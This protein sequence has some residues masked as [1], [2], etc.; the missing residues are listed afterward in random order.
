MI[1]VLILICVLILLVIVCYVYYGGLNTVICRVENQKEE[2]IVY[3][4]IIGDYKKT[5]KYT[6]KIYYELLDKEKIETTRGIAIFY[7]NPRQTDKS[8]LRSDVGCILNNPDHATLAKLSANYLVK[9]L[10]GNSFITTEFPIKGSL[11][12]IIGVIKAYPALTKYCQKE[13]IK[14]SPITEIYDIP[15]KKII[16]RKEVVR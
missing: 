4:P 12:F 6:N 9:T 7:D 16:Y 13:G 8:K 15:N 3:E 11:S 5:S 14:E 1:I 2:V 10:P